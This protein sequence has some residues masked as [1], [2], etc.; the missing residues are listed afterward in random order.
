MS[1]KIEI[2]DRECYEYVISRGFVPLL[3]SRFYMDI[4]L[5]VQMQRETFGHCI[6]GRGNIPAANERF[7]RFMWENSR[8]VCEETF[9]PLKNY[10]S[11][12][13]SHI[14][15]RGAAPDMA[16]DPRNVNILCYDAHQLWE[17][18]GLLEREKMRIYDKNKLTIEMLKKEYQRL[19]L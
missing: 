2:V 11:G 9:M 4:N 1:E 18:G 8:H 16:H 5:R 3:D 7:Y 14:I 15:S 6:I 17:N 12:H 10:W 13:I 19:R